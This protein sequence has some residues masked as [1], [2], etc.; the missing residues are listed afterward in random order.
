MVGAGP[1][2]WSRAAACR[3]LCTGSSALVFFLLPC[4]RRTAAGPLLLPRSLPP[5]APPAPRQASPQA[6]APLPWLFPPCTPCR[7]ASLLAGQVAV[8][9]TFPLLGLTL[10]RAL[11][12]GR[13]CELLPGDPDA[14]A[15]LQRALEHCNLTPFMELLSGP[16]VDDGAALLAEA[17]EAALAAKVRISACSRQGACM[18]IDSGRHTTPA[19]PRPAPHPS[20]PHSPPPACC[21]HTPCPR[22][23]LLHPHARC[24]TQVVPQTTGFL[25]KHDWLRE[26]AADAGLAKELSQKSLKGKISAVKREVME[27]QASRVHAGCVCAP[28]RCLLLAPGMHA[29]R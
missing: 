25:E 12:E 26:L 5:H 7:Q 24:R 15:T 3:K 17:L 10:V 14:K 13:A 9:P 11:A 19:L 22:T 21:T 23:R 1:C 6:G 27:R 29:H 18:H 4:E 8:V 28:M 20:H 16:T 2:H